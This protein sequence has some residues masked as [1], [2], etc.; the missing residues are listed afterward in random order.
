M[1][2]TVLERAKPRKAPLAYKEADS[3]GLKGADGKRLIQ[4]GKCTEK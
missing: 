1:S 2:A 3:N 4:D